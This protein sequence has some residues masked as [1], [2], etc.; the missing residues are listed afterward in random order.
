MEQGARYRVT[1]RVLGKG[2]QDAAGSTAVDNRIGVTV[3]WV[4]HS[5]SPFTGHGGSDWGVVTSGEALIR[6]LAIE[7]GAAQVR[8]IEVAPVR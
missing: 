4:R 6:G 2:K 3:F 7:A 5:D 8:M 1:A